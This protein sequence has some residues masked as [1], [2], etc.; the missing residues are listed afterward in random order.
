MRKYIVKLI[1]PAQRRGMKFVGIVGSETRRMHRE[2]WN[3]CREVHSPHKG[4]G[5][6]NDR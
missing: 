5:E 3:E 1:N 6:V 2:E 4:Q